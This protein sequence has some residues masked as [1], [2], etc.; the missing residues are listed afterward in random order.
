MGQ[1]LYN[2]IDRLYYQKPVSSLFHYTSLNGLKGIIESNSIW[3]TEARYLNDAEEMSHLA[4]RVVDEIARQTRVHD[5]TERIILKQFSTWIKNR[6][7]QGHKMF[8]A[9]FTENGNLLS[10][11]RGYCPY[12]KGISIGFSPDKISEI[13]QGASYT[14]GKCI[15]DASQQSTIVGSIIG[16]VVE[17][18]FRQ[19][20]S[21]DFHESQSYYGVFGELEPAILRI[22]ILIKNV[23]FVEEQEWRL[24]SP[25]I[26]NYRE[27]SISYREGTSMLIPYM[28]LPIRLGQDKD[29]IDLVIIGPTPT[30]KLAI[31]SL[32]NY[33]GDHLR[34]VKVM[35]S[36]S[37][38]RQ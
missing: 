13:M 24:I 22:A 3:A 10:Q 8:V 16:G 14:L 21:A 30:P 12:G 27:A 23:A 4:E 2:V 25:I 6:L 36:Q 1:L 11:W 38:Y 33:L 20:P 34:T 9:S 15:Y 19:G 5:E 17:E 29:D 7:T 18:A 32:V 37:P 31:D 26:D 28:N 35:N